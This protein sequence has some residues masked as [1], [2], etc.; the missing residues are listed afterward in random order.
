MAHTPKPVSLTARRS[1]MPS[2]GTLAV[3]D[4]RTTNRQRQRISARLVGW[5]G[6]DEVPCTI[7][8]LAA[9]GAYVQAPRGCEVGLGYRYELVIEAPADSSEFTRALSEGCYATVVRTEV[10]PS[11]SANGIGAGLRFDQP[12][13]L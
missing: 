13:L 1:S 11:G 3:D 12:L 4:R 9:G 8:D 5:G 7:L 10:L 2:S 6:A